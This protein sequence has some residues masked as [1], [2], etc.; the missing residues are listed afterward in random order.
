M[1]S[2]WS[3]TPEPRGLQTPRTMNRWHCAVGEAGGTEDPGFVIRQRAM[4]ALSRPENKGEGEQGLYLFLPRWK[5]ADTISRRPGGRLSPS[6]YPGNA[7]MHV[8]VC[9]RVC[10]CVWKG[11]FAGFVP[12]RQTCFRVFFVSVHPWSTCRLSLSLSAPFLSFPQHEST[13]M[14]TPWRKRA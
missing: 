7:R 11:S 14:C 8:C 13:T 10:A 4:D 9:V 2:Y 5:T 12:R 1:E 3:A 6:L